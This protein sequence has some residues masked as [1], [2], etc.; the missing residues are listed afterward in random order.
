MCYFYSN[1]KTNDVHLINRT[2]IDIMIKENEK[3]RIECDEITYSSLKGESFCGTI[4]FS[5]TNWLKGVV[6]RDPKINGFMME[7][8][9]GT[10]IKQAER[11][12][13]YR[14][15][16]Q[17]YPSSI[18]SLNRELNKKINE[19][20]RQL[21]KIIANMRIF[22]FKE[23]IYNFKHVQF[24]RENCYECDVLFEL[25]AQHYGLQTHW[26]D[27][28]NDFMCALFFA[29][30]FHDGK[31]WYPLTKK[32]TEC[33]ENTKYGMIFH[34]PYC[35]VSKDFSFKSLLHDSFGCRINAIL[36]IGFQPFMR[37]HMQYGYGIYMSED[38]SLQN[39]ISFEKLKFRHDEKLSQD[40][41]NKMKEGE[42]IYPHEGLN[43]FDDI[44]CQI[45]NA[46]NF[47]DGAFEYAF[48]NNTYFTDKTYCKLRLEQYEIDNK[49]I[50]IGNDHPYTLC[51]QRRRRLDKQYET[52][53][54]EKSYNIKPVT[55]LVSPPPN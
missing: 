34:I 8:P 5:P 35:N 53:S 37:C 43:S 29:T 49:F 12:H 27:I 50:T 31:K 32:Q 2:D 55:R 14:G 39:D 21:Y 1:P 33:N 18:P 44:I 22:E 41:Y 24:W 19:E 9:Y 42:L 4:G 40:V 47:T 51:R 52:F 15:E 25:L 30:C 46:I 54:L 23:F 7:M 3:D 6:C 28:T 16:K 10:V 20:D 13:Y 48:Q 11:N 26:L 36:P 38:Y 45:K 17:I